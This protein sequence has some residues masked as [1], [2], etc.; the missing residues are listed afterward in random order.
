MTAELQGVVATLYIPLV[1]RIHVSR[2]F[3]DFFR[4]DMALALEKHLPDGCSEV[5]VSEYFHM[6]G[7]CRYRVVDDILRAFMAQ[8][9]Q[10]NII[11][12][13]AGLETCFFRLQPEHACFYEL[14]LPPVIAMREKL[15][16][17]HARDVLLASDL[18][19][20]AWADAVDA[21]LPTVLT[22]SGVFQYFEEEKIRRFIAAVKER[23]T[24]AELVFDAM[25]SPALA[26]ANRFVRK[27]GNK[28][29]VMHFS[30]NH[31]ETFGAACGMRL[32]EQRPFFTEARKL[33]KKELSLST[34][35]AM[36]LADESCLR[37][38]ILRYAL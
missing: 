11:N 32:L 2:R 26:F 15:L 33:L 8:Q 14:D 21:S 28:N 13:G 25:T 5:R 19:E 24:H 7:A 16:G 38:F 3:P 17:A 29:A 20:L 30:V 12:L 23:F 36:K 9:R 10:C 6:A 37:S 34:R 1:A 35:I 4:D 22:A 27:T 18:F 31:P